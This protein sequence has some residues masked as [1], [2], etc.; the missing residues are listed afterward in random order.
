MTE[1]EPT[2]DELSRH[3]QRVSALS[4]DTDFG[5]II[6]TIGLISEAKA[7]LTELQKLAEEIAVEQLRR[8]GRKTIGTCS[9]WAGPTRTYKSK[10]L[11][12]T[13]EVV[14]QASGGDW[15]RFTDCLSTGAM[16]HGAVRKLLTDAGTPEKFDEVF[17]TVETWDLKDDGEKKPRLQKVDSKFLK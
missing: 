14:F 11:L 3:V 5:D 9:Y 6:N 13:V 7:R 16:K 12:A 8:D 10:D 17:E 15:S 1:T 4:I 2:T